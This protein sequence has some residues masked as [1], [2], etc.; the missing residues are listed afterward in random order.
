[1]T[2]PNKQNETKYP[3]Y[4]V[5]GSGGHTAE[6]CT[7]NMALLTS[8]RGKEIYNPLRYIIANDDI[9]SRSRITSAMQ[10]VG[11][12]LDDTSFIYVPRSRK[13]GQSYLSS[14]F[15]TLW[16]LLWSFWLVWSGQPKLL[17]CNGPGTCVP[18]CVATYICR[19]IRRLPSKTKIVFVESWCRVRTLSLSGKLLR[20]FLDLLVVQWPALAE[21]YKNAYNVKYFGKI[22]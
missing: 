16:A 9:T 2:S 12:A 22:M 13:V 15:T 4:I 19:R 21:K 10:K 14:V 1:M 20:P 11:V 7:I 18:F 6:M 3:V 5:L 17:L 8:A